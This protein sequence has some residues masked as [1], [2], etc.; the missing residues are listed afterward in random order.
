LRNLGLFDRL[1]FSFNFD[2]RL[3]NLSYLGFQESKP[4]IGF[5]KQLFGGQR[6]DQQLQFID[7]Y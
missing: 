1:V 4:G 5:E 6:F 3:T 2:L 7:R